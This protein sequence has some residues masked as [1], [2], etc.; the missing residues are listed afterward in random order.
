MAYRVTIKLTKTDTNQWCFLRDDISDAMIQKL[1]FCKDIGMDLLND[2]VC[3][4]SEAVFTRDFDDKMSA[5][6]FLIKLMSIP[7]FDTEEEIKAAHPAG[8]TEETTT[9]EI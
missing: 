6:R 8:C 4:P 1:T 9:E 5:N 3:T 7:D 2:F